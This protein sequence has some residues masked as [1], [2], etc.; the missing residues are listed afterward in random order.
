MN[1][2]MYE[3]RKLSS[4]EIDQQG[5]IK[6]SVEYRKFSDQ[7]LWE[8]YVPFFDTL[9]YS[10]VINPNYDFERQYVLEDG[11]YHRF[12]DANEYIYL[13]Q[14]RGYQI[15]D[16]CNSRYQYISK[17]HL[18]PIQLSRKVSTPL[19]Q[20]KTLIGALAY[21]YRG[22]AIFHPAK[23]ETKGGGYFPHAHILLN[24]PVADQKEYGEKLSSLK[25]R[26]DKFNKFRIADD[27]GSREIN[28]WKRYLRYCLG[29]NRKYLKEISTSVPLEPNVLWIKPER[30]VS[31]ICANAS[32]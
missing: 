7:P 29:E 17:P 21:R 1:N 12:D 8:T 10:I 3:Y 13:A 30:Q 31:L 15:L 18:Q 11:E 25:K 2:G 27:N 22:I 14:D 16:D 4:K 26:K 24:V 20:W 9:N 5:N 23:T 6:S 19:S 32:N 28:N